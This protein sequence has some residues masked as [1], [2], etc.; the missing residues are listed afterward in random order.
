LKKHQGDSL[1]VGKKALRRFLIMDHPI[2]E[3]A[4]A[5]QNQKENER[6]ATFLLLGRRG[7]HRRCG[8]PRRIGGGHETGKILGKASRK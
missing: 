2:T 1:D 6:S 5:K 7:R 4:A 3:S 8:R